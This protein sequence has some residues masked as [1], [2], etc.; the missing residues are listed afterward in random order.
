MPPSWADEPSRVAAY[1]VFFL[2]W[3]MGSWILFTFVAQ[4][5]ATEGSE[6]VQLIMTTW[7]ITLAIEQVETIPNVLV[8]RFTSQLVLQREPYVG[9]VMNRAMQVSS[10]QQEP[11]KRLY[12]VTQ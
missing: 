9:L 11:E 1:S 7:G 4:I 6:T 10:F 5:R 2:G 3:M 8:S 12:D